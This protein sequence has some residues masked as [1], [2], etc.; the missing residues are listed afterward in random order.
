MQSTEL[1]FMGNHVFGQGTRTTEHLLKI[2]GEFEQLLSGHASYTM[3]RTNPLKVMSNLSFQE[4]GQTGGRVADVIPTTS[5]N[6]PFAV[7]VSAP[8]CPFH[9]WVA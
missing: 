5:L 3:V 1:G 6:L 9:L 4:D 8:T 2:H 7:R